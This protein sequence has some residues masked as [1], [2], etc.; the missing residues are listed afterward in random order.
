MPM[1]LPC[2]KMKHNIIYYISR[3]NLLTEEKDMLYN[4]IF[5]R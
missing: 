3:P 5:A 1:S 4:E 2:K